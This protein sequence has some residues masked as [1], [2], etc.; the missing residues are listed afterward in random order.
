MLSLRVLFE[1]RAFRYYQND[2]SEN[3]LSSFELSKLGCR[4]VNRV[5]KSWHLSEPN[6]G[7]GL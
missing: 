5:W 1:T 4:I 3:H 2:M 7:C 6:P